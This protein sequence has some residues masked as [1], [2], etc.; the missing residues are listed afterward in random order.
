MQINRIAWNLPHGII[1]P[2]DELRGLFVQLIGFGSMTLALHAHLMCPTAIA[3][4]VRL[5]GFGG[6]VLMLALFFAGEIAESIVFLLG[7]GGR[8]VVEC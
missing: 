4:F 8:A 6:E 7:G 1:L 3:A 2:E 5:S